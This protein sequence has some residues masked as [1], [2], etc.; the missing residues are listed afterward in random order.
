M[1][2]DTRHSAFAYCNCGW[3]LDWNR[4]ICTHDIL[5]T[6]SIFVCALSF[7][8]DNRHAL[9]WMRFNKSNDIG[10]GLKNNLLIILWGPYLLY[11]FFLFIY[12]WIDGRQRKVWSPPP[13]SI[14]FFLFL[15]IAYTILRNLPFEPFITFLAPVG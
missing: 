13:I 1:S 12:S 15:T 6:R 9:S 2:N 5:S 10:L 7:P 14:I 3:H 11:R 8:H 4:S